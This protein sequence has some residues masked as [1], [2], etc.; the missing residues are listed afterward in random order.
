MKTIFRLTS[1]LSVSLTLAILPGR[2]LA[3]SMLIPV[4]TAN[5]A[6]IL[7]VEPKKD[8]HTVYFGRRLAENSEYAL[9]SSVYRQPGD[10]TG[11][12]NSAYTPSGSRNLIEPAITVAH[13]DGNYSL[14]LRFVSQQVT[15]LSDD[16][17]LLTILLKDPVYDFEV[18]LYYKSYYSSD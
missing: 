1:L 10:P 17:S 2:L 18:T 6:L 12:F 3:Q 7:R 5:N 16:V 14:D 15:K 9:V 11:L 13:A 8:L 4:E